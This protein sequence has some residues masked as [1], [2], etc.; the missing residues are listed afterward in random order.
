MHVGRLHHGV[1]LLDGHAAPRSAGAVLLG[2]AGGKDESGAAG[3][4]ERGAGSAERRRAHKVM[5][6][7][8]SSDTCRPEAPRL[9]YLMA[10]FFE[11]RYLRSDIVKRPKTAYE[12][13]D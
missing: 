1:G 7:K 9:L 12:Y 3:S 11:L 8:D 4:R 2:A 10:V 5:Q 6:P 13:S